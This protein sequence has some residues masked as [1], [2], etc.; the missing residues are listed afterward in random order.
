MILYCAGSMNE[1]LEM[2]ERSGAKNWLQTFAGTSAQALARRMVESN[3][4]GGDWLLFVDSGAFSVWRNGKQMDLSAYIAFAREILEQC[5]RPDRIVFAA[6]DMIAGDFR[7]PPMPR[8]YS[9]VYAQT[10]QQS[11]DNAQ[12]MRDEL[13]DLCPTIIPTF[14]QGD[15]WRFLDTLIS[16][17]DYIALSPKKVEKTSLQKMEWMDKCFLKIKAAGRLVS[18]S[19]NPL[20]VHGLGVASPMFMERFPFYSVDSTAWLQAANAGCY[21]YY[22]GSDTPA[23]GQ[24]DWLKPA[25]DYSSERKYGVPAQLTAVQ[26]YRDRGECKGV[27]YLHETAMRADVPL[28]AYITRFWERNGVRWDD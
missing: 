19:S 27:Y 11:L 25:L 5:W 26:N 6:L 8:E 3:N 14:H 4:C 12:R 9:T 16:E 21:R 10:S 2:G 28:E 1:L 20:K 23:A 15:P 24:E 22:C 18:E 17:F 13:A 7:N